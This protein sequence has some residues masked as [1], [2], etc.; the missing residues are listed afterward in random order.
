VD[1][2]PLDGDRREALLGLLDDPNPSVRGALQAYFLALGPTAAALL[3]EAA[4]GPN[5]I[6][7]WHARRYLEELRFTD[8][9]A[10]FRDFIRAQHYDL[11]AGSLLLSRT[12]NPQADTEASSA[13]LDEM[14][15]RCRELIVEPGTTREKCRV[16]N[17][18]LFHESGFRGNVEDY[19]DPNNSFLDQV[20]ARRRGIP[21]SLSIVYL[22][23][24]RR[25][26]VTLEPVGLPG[27]FV[28]GCF[29]TGEPF[30]IDPFEGGTMLTGT[31]VSASLRARNLHVTESEL[32]PTPV[33]E[34]LCRTCRNLANHCRASGDEARSQLFAGFV[35]EFAATYARS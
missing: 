16:I 27:H 9:V 15:T 24:A 19:T 6:L 7:A 21:V 33:R 26:G 22:L 13:L 18:V 12:V 32:I 25:L 23:V 5:R 34:V 10:E 17:R 31:E 30:F 2:L 3:K 29:L 1:N 11:E 4:A 35:A 8:P 20:L 28:V 14:A